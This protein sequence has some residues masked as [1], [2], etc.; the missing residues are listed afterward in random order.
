MILSKKL[1]SI[2][3]E[4][5]V[6]HF[7]VQSLHLPEIAVVQAGMFKHYIAP[8]NFSASNLGSENPGYNFDV[9]VCVMVC[10]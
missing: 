1:K 3:K 4:V 5:A 6:A 9:Q 2:C 7:E 8:F 10:S